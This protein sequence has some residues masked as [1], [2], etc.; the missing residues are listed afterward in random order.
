MSLREALCI[1]AAFK[2]CAVPE[3]GIPVSEN[4]ANAFKVFL[5]TLYGL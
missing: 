4:A 3:G 2:Y 1:G 5:Y